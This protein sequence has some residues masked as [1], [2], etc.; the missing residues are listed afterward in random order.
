MGKGD[1]R[2]KPKLPSVAPTPRPRSRGRQRMREIEYEAREPVVAAR[3]RQV[4]G[5]D[6][7]AALDPLCGSGVGRCIRAIAREP[8][9]LHTTWL[10]YG[11]AVLQYRRCYIGQTG[12][13]MAQRVEMMRE[14]FEVPE[15]HSVDTRTEEERAR[16]AVTRYMAWQGYLMRLSREDMRRIVESLDAEDELYWRDGDAT[17]TG[18]LL[19][20]AL[21]RLARVVAA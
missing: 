16:A 14:R 1:R 4:P 2:K 9:Q 19:V 10:D 6:A 13:P 5:L 17:V 8:K 15:G 21:E 18:E 11:Q 3:R 20:R 12:L 7:K